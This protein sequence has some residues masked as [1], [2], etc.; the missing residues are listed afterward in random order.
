MAQ[1]SENFIFIYLGL[2]LFTERKLV[3]KP[4]FILISIVGICVARWCAV[5]PLSRLIN[6]AIRYKA[7]KRGISDPEEM[8]YAHQVMLF[9]A[10]LRGAVGVALAAGLAGAN[11][12]TLRRGI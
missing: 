10:G 1:L 11:G 4:L 7:R 9:W 2:S 3:F 5:F 8:P 12:P 6:W